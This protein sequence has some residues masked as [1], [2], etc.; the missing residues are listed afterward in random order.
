VK[1]EHG[2]KGTQPGMGLCVC[3][4][5]GWLHGQLDWERVWLKT[6]PG[7]AEPVVS[8]SRYLI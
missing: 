2:R 3:S 8:Q 4:Q 1:R 5:S 7:L 6:A